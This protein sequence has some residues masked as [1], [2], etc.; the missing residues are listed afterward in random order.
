MLDWFGKRT[1][2][3]V[4]A[5]PAQLVETYNVEQSRKRTDL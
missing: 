2:D 3:T 4:N 1:I 5:Y